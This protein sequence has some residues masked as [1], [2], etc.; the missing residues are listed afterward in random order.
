MTKQTPRFQMNIGFNHL[1]CS[2]ISWEDSMYVRTSSDGMF[3]VGAL[4]GGRLS[5]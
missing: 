4:H 5:R 3:S 2:Y 1:V